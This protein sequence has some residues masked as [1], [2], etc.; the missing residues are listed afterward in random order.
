MSSIQDRLVA[1]EVEVEI[2]KDQLMNTVDALHN[3]RR[4]GA[5]KNN[6]HV[7]QQSSLDVSRVSVK[8]QKSSENFPSSTA[9]PPSP[10]NIEYE[11]LLNL[12]R[13]SEGKLQ[14]RMNQVVEFEKWKA[15]TTSTVKELND[16]VAS[17]E[18]KLHLVTSELKSVSAQYYD[19]KS[20]NEELEKKL[21]H[22]KLAN[23]KENSNK[24]DQKLSHTS[25]SLKLLQQKM[26][27]EETKHQVEM[28][29]M[30]E[31]IKYLE[32]RLSSN[33]STTVDLMRQLQHANNKCIELQ[34]ENDRLNV[35]LS[36]S[37]SA[38]EASELYIAKLKELIKNQKTGP[39][40]E[41]VNSLTPS[42]D[43]KQS[44]PTNYYN[45]T[46][47]SKLRA[48]Y[49]SNKKALKQIECIND[50]N[51][52]VTS[53]FEEKDEFIPYL[54]TPNMDDVVVDDASV[55]T[56]SQSSIVESLPSRSTVS[57]SNKSSKKKITRKDLTNETNLTVKHPDRISEILTN[58]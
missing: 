36:K 7:N 20:I 13:I 43:P 11:K 58:S 40:N 48:A 1:K 16:K 41:G 46:T 24:T 18:K 4:N 14:Y 54:S 50:T 5:V 33:S 21:E 2:L 57:L 39:S 10:N 30:A 15:E 17:Y 55:S 27:D 28:Q 44:R 45:E 25:N 34:I 52:N 3:E 29:N 53:H 23:S 35:T 31:N 9:A 42:K 12:Y 49:I 19:C 6:D 47:A 37:I 51:D 8:S 38:T 56:S 32:D 26:I 22:E